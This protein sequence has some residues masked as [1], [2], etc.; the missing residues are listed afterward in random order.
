M[1][2]ACLWDQALRAQICLGNEGFVKRMQKR[3]ITKPS[4]EIPRAQYRKARPLV[5]YFSKAKRDEVIRLAYRDGG[6]TQTAIAEAAGLSVS[7]VSSL[8]AKLEVKGKTLHLPLTLA[9]IFLLLSYAATRSNTW[10]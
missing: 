10:Q 6:H 1:P 7:R 2:F 4:R 5:D 8:I 9:T 3:I